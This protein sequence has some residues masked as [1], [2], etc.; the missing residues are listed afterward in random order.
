M[1]RP[2]PVSAGGHCS[3]ADTPRLVLFNGNS[4]KREDGLAAAGLNYEN[5]RP[6][7]NYN[8]LNLFSS[9]STFLFGVFL[10]CFS[11]TEELN[12]VL[13]SGLVNL[14]PPVRLTCN[15]IIKSIS[16]TGS[17]TGRPGTENDERSSALGGNQATTDCNS[18]SRLIRDSTLE[19]TNKT[20][21]AHLLSLT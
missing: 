13:G 17:V 7:S 19:R 5:Y 12:G 8:P 6:S 15:S 1:F 18:T 3:V 14:S 2:L 9:R 21:G 20:S 4:V 10:L 11:F 16:V